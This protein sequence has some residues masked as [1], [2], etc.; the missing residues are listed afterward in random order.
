[1][2]RSADIIGI[3]LRRTDLNRRPSGYEPA[4][5][6]LSVIFLLI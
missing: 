5:L 3:W 2:V 1:M 4:I 6:R